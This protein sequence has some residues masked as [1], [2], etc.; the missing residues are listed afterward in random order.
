[1]KF[2]QGQAGANNFS[3]GNKASYWKRKKVSP[4]I[5]NQPDTNKQNIVP[6][7]LRHNKFVDMNSNRQGNCKVS[8]PKGYRKEYRSRIIFKEL[9]PVCEKLIKEVA[10]CMSM[11]FSNEDKPIHFDC[12]INKLK[13]ENEILKNEDLIY[14]GIGKFFVVDKS[15]R[16]NN[17]TFKIVREIDFENLEGRP[18]WRKKIL[19]DMNKGFKFD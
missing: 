8:K 3:K 5:K 2:N 4:D 14:R 6:V 19:K 15:S 12:A 11:K 1:M 13:S 10:S 16:G 7:G 18:S 17:L 9:C